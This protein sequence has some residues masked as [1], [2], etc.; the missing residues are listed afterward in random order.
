MLEPAERSGRAGLKYLPLRLIS[1]DSNRSDWLS[2]VGDILP[3]FPPP[4]T[5]TTTRQRVVDAQ[6][7]TVTP[8]QFV[9]HN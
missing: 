3:L 2:A 7:I 8:F 1:I 5:T 4:P 9:S 6:L